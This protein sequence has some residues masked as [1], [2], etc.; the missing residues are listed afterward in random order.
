MS[1]AC[2]A[3]TCLVSARVCFVCEVRARSLTCLRVC[4]RTQLTSLLLHVC[5]LCVLLVVCVARVKR[6]RAASCPLVPTLLL[7]PTF[8]LFLPLF[9][10]FFPHSFPLFPTLSH[11][12]SFSHS[13]PLFPTLSRPSPLLPWWS[14]TSAVYMY[15]CCT[16]WTI[17]RTVHVQ[18]HSSLHSKAI[19]LKVFVCSTLLS[20][21]VYRNYF[22]F[23]CLLHVLKSV[24]FKSESL[25]PS[26]TH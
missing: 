1:R 4:T 20:E 5:M 8:P 14:V 19:F 25:A 24:T 17:L 16:F 21:K 3:Y 22:I 2:L 15:A 23:V 6:A 18:V 12:V 7:P 9:F 11:C 26:L 13:F 10:F